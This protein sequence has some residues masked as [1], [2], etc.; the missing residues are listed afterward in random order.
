MKRKKQILCTSL[1]IVFN[2]LILGNLSMP[3]LLPSRIHNA[4]NVP[5][6]IHKNVGG[7]Y[8]NVY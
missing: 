2:V 6:I 5:E 8:K 4:L 1:I 3:T 7:L